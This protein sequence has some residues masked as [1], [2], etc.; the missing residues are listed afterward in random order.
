MMWRIAPALLLL[1]AAAM[2]A[3]Q[4]NLEDLE[5]RL[6]EAQ[7][8]QAEKQERERREG[9]Q[10]AQSA[11]KAR[12]EKEERDRREAAQKAQAVQKAKAEKEERDRREAEQNA[13]AVQK[14]KAEKEERDRREAEQKAQAVQEAITEKEERDRREAAQRAQAERLERERREAAQKAQTE[15]ASRASVSP[16][17]RLDLD[18]STT[19]AHTWKFQAYVTTAGA[20]V[21]SAPGTISLVEKDGRAVFS[22]SAGRQSLCHRGELDAVVTRTDATTI[23][24]VPPRAAGC[25]E[26]R[27]VLNNDG[28]GGQLQ[29]KQG[30]DWVWDGLER[31]LTLHK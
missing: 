17:R 22:I 25:D 18:V 19:T 6:K 15:E 2:A 14:A 29:V 23:I 4:P 13:Q 21:P 26:I 24:T 28:T 10:K 16:N 31:G 7:K 3:E 30:R 12:A 27:F 9:D 1:T 8:A 11:Q 20:P 5:R